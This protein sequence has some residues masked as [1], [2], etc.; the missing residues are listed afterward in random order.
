MTER[1]LSELRALRVIGMS[2]SAL[3]YRPAPDRNRV[4]RERVV[5]SGIAAMA[6]G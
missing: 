5:L 3:R 4:L 6:R 2:A 1:G